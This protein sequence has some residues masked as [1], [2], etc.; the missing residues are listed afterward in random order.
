MEEFLK[1]TRY[2]N[3]AALKVLLPKFKGLASKA[4]AEWKKS[5]T[6]K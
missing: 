4:E 6:E 5:A 1:K 2:P 3:K